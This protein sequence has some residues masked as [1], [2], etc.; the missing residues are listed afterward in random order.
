M[1]NTLVLGYM[2]SHTFVLLSIQLG[3]QILEFLK[4]RYPTFLLSYY[5]QLNHD[6]EISVPILDPTRNKLGVVTL[7]LIITGGP[8]IYPIF[9]GYGILVAFQLISRVGIN[10]ALMFELF[11]NWMP[12]L[13]GVIVVIVIVSIVVIEFKQA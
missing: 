2:V 6:E 9:A 13:I 3:V 10:P 12:P 5:F 11:L 7:L 1:L 4:I 8:I